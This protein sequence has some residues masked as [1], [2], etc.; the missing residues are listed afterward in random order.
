MIT[1]IQKNILIP[2]FIWLALAMPVN[3]WA[4]EKS[5]ENNPQEFAAYIGVIHGLE[6]IFIPQHSVAINIS[7]IFTGVG[8]S[9]RFYLD[10]TTDSLFFGGT[11]L[12]EALGF[13]QEAPVHNFSA[14][15]GRRF[16]SDAFFLDLGGGLRLSF[17]DGL[18]DAIH[19]ELDDDIYF[20]LLLHLTIGMRF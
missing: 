11:Y 16:L 13:S 10:P 12:F 3:L 1:N 5:A 6:Y 8:G 20:G 2:L 15:I 7:I 19:L 17:V 9:Y 4:Q 14:Y 18:N